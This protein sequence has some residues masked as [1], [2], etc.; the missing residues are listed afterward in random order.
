MHGLSD[1]LIGLAVFG[2]FAFLL[3]THRRGLRSLLE[4]IDVTQALGLEPVRWRVA[5]VGAVEGCRVVMTARSSDRGRSLVRVRVHLP[6]PLPIRVRR[7]PRHAARVA[8]GTGLAIGWPAFDEQVRVQGEELVARALL[9]R[10]TRDA[11]M[12]F[13]GAGGRFDGRRVDIWWLSQ[14]GETGSRARHAVDAARALNRAAAGLDDPLDTLLQIAERDPVAAVR[15]ATLGALIRHTPDEPWTTRALQTALIDGDPAVRRV[16]AVRL[17]HAETLEGLLSPDVPADDQRAAVE[18]L[19]R[20]SD[21][22]DRIQRRLSMLSQEARAVAIDAL[23]AD[24]RGRSGGLALAPSAA[25]EL[26]LSDAED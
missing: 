21:G 8:V 5:R 10:E 18:A 23:R 3:V 6:T 13:V 17:L 7:M 12:P 26:A 11:L 22:L 9:S 24:G 25:G 1:W 2:F 20:C 16:A 19:L 15:A 14:N 4:V